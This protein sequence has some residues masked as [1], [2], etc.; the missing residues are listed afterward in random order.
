MAI[1]ISGTTVIDDSRNIVNVVG[2]GATYYRETVNN[3]GNTGATPNINYASGGFVVATLD[4]TATFTFSNPPN[5]GF[6]SFALQLTN[7]A[8]SLSITWPGVVKWPGGVQPVRTETINRTD[9]Y[10]FY[11]VDGGTNWYGAI[12]QYD[13]N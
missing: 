7:G 5:D 6:Y 12:S 1:K 10:S 2:I 13:Y 3:L 8:G 4:Q 9:I 11:T